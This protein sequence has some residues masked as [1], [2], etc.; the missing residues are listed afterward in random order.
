MKNCTVKLIGSIENSLS[1]KPTEIDR[2]DLLCVS[3]V[4]NAVTFVSLS[5]G[6]ET[7]IGRGA[8]GIETATA[9]LRDLI[10]IKRSLANR[11]LF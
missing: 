3:G 9:I 6:E 8:G 1:V 2:N 4:R 10:Q 5:A 7:I 11:Q